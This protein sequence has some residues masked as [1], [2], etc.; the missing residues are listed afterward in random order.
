M[1][2]NTTALQTQVAA[3]ISALSST[4]TAEDLLLLSLAVKN[5]DTNRIV[6]VPT[7]NDL[8]SLYSVTDPRPDPGTIFFI[9]QNFVPVVAGTQNWLGLDGRVARRDVP[10]TTAWGWGTNGAPIGDGTNINRSSPTSVIGNFTDWCIVNMGNPVAASSSTIALKNNGTLWSWGVGFL[11][12]N[13]TTGTVSPIR[14]ASDSTDWCAIGEGSFAIKRDGTLWTWGCNAGGYLGD[15]TTINRSSPVSVVGGFTDWCQISNNSGHSLAVRKNGTLWSW[16]KNQSGKLGDGTIFN[17]SSPVSVIGGIIDWCQASAGYAHSLAIRS[18]GTAWAWGSNIYGRLGNNS[19]SVASSPVAVVGGF[20]D[21]CQIATGYYSSAAV[22]SNGTAWA[23]GY[24][25]LGDGT[26]CTRSSPVSIVGG[27]TNWCKVASGY[28][29]TAGIRTDGT[30]WAWGW[31]PG[32]NTAVTKLSPVSVAGGF[33]TWSKLGTASR[34]GQ[35][36]IRT[37]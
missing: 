9:E 26:G 27:F 14:V 12:D 3:L 23:W 2:V 22:R 20:T 37:S 32:D 31:Q 11:G 16:G 21:W 15:G 24:G 13:N 10:S 6:S 4:A 7:I 1:P 30:L 35:I 28:K 25:P 8:P 33:T 34:C 36:A 19:T 18:N 17:K 5:L 29:H